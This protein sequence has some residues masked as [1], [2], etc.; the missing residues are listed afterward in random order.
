MRDR[1]EE[2]ERDWFLT[3]EDPN[4]NEA[5]KEISRTDIRVMP[6]G[7]K[8]SRVAFVLEC[9]RLNTPAS[10]A[11]EYTGAGGMMCF[12]TGKYSPGMPCAGMLGFIMD[13]NV[14]R[15]HKSVVASVK[16]NRRDLKMPPKATYRSCAWLGSHGL[17]GK[18]LHRSSAGIFSIYHLLLPFRRR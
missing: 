7:Q 12:I 1:Y 18:T 5:G 13:G 14:A 6:P 10:N 4:W 11:S 8:R 15:A 9:K 3:I 17:H 2:E 16:T